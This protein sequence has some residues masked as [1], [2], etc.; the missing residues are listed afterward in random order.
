MVTG[1]AALC[2][3]NMNVISSAISVWSW[4]SHLLLVLEDIHV[5]SEKINPPG[6]LSTQQQI[7]WRRNVT[8]LLR[9]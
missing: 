3:Y 7:A 6:A 2:V 4:V 8:F 9:L 1:L 5:M